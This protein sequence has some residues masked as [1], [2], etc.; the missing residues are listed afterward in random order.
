MHFDVPG[1]VLANVE[2]DDAAAEPTTRGGRLVSRAPATFKGVRG[3][4]IRIAINMDHL[5]LF[6]SQSGDALL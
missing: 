1:I 5:Q 6:D 2:V 4:R 3:D